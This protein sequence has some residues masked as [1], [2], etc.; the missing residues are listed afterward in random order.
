MNMGQTECYE[1]SAY[2]IQTPENYP[3]KSRQ[4]SEYGESLKSTIHSCILRNVLSGSRTHTAATYK[5]GTA[6]F[7]TGNK[8]AGALRWTLTFI[9]WCLLDWE[10]LRPPYIMRNDNCTFMQLC[11]IDDISKFKLYT[12]ITSKGDLYRYHR[13]LRILAIFLFLNIS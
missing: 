12:I 6:D 1:T 8:T 11:F 7:F 2:K 4:H 10:E 5:K 13:T 9:R 3:E